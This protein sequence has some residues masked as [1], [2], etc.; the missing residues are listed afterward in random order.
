M[1]IFYT[2]PVDLYAFDSLE[3]FITCTEQL[4]FLIVFTVREW[5]AKALVKYLFKSLNVDFRRYSTLFAFIPCCTVPNYLV[6]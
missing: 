6:M 1:S 4:T 2:R 5:N 3:N